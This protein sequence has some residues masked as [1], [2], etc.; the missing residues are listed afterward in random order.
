MADALRVTLLDNVDS[1]TFNLVDEFARR[2]AAVTVF[3]NDRSVDEIVAHATGPGP[4]LVVVSPGPG[5]PA[6]AGASRGVVEAVLGRS[7]LFGVC[8]GHQVLIACEGGRVCRTPTPLHGRAT[9]LVH[10]GREPFTDLPSP[11]PV[12]RY[13]SL[14]A[15]ALPPSLEPTAH[16]DGVVMAV[17]H[18]RLP[19]IGVQFHPESVLTPEGGRLIDNVMAWARHA[20]H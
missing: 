11:M 2:G 16:S 20:S 13:H 15:L 14:S 1:F 5:G 6:E 8:L 3:R 19:A 10:E 7:P 4:R 18:R 9:I 12:A 17:R